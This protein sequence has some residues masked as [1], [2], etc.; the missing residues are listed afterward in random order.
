[1]QKFLIWMLL[2]NKSN[3]DN[4]Q[5]KWPHRML[6]IGPCGSG[7]TNALLNLIQK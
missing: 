5:K 1:M 4:H 6:I 7:K 2:Q 3:K